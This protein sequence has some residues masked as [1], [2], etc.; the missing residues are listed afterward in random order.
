MGLSALSRAMVAM[1]SAAVEGGRKLIPKSK[2]LRKSILEFGGEGSW[3][4]LLL[5]VGKELMMGMG[6]GSE[7]TRMI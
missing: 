6:N 3:L 4:S 7:M 1:M 5:E 2:R